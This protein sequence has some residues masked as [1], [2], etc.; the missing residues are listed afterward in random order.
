MAP[1][2]ISKFLIILALVLFVLAGVGMSSGMFVL[3]WFGLALLAASML[4]P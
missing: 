4:V 1:F 2:T 3:G